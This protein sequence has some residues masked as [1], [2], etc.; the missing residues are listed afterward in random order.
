MSTSDLNTTES[1]LGISLQ[2]TVDTNEIDEVED[3]TTLA[4]GD[5]VGADTDAS[6][7]VAAS[8]DTAGD[9]SSV[10]AD[11]DIAT[12]ASA[13]VQEEAEA[14]DEEDAASEIADDDSTVLA[15]SDAIASASDDGENASGS[16]DE[17]DASAP[18]SDEDLSARA[19]GDVLISAADENDAETLTAAEEEETSST[20]TD[21]STTV[22]VAGSSSPLT[23]ETDKS[24]YAPGETAIITATDVTVGGTVEFQ[25]SHLSAGEDGVLLTSDDVVDDEMNA[26]GSGHESWLVTDGAVPDDLDGEANGTIVTSWY[27]NPDD[28]GG[29]T[30][31]LSA[32]EL[33]TGKSATTFFTDTEPSSPTLDLTDADGT[34]SGV[35]NGAFFTI[36]TGVGGT[37]FIDSF[38]RVQA[39]GNNDG[40]EQGYN[41]DNE[42]QF[43]AKGVVQAEEFTH[44]ILLSDVPRFTFDPDGA[45]ALPLGVYR[46]FVLDVNEPNDG[47]NALLSLDALQIFLGNEPDLLH[48][49]ENVFNGFGG[50]AVLVYD[51]EDS[52]VALSGENSHL[53]AGSGKVNLKVYISDSLFQDADDFPYVYLYSA[54]GFQ[55][56]DWK[57]DGG[58]EEW[59]VRP[60]GA[61]GINVSGYKWDDTNGNGE[62]DEGEP[63]IAG[64]TIYLDTDDDLDNGALATTTNGDGHYAFTNLGAGTYYVYEASNADWTNTYDGAT[65]FTA[66][67]LGDHVG[68]FETTEALNF[69]NFKLFDISGYKWNDADGDSLWDEGE[70]GIAGWTIYLDDDDDP[71]NG[72]LDSTDTDANGFYHF[73]NV[74]PG[75]YHVYE[76]SVPNWTNTFDGSLT[77]TAQSGADQM[78]DFGVAEPL[79]FGNHEFEGPGVRT[80]GFWSSPIGKPFWDGIG[81]NESK[82]GQTGFAD[83][84]L[85]YAVDSDGNGTLD[86]V[87][88]LL[89][90]DYDHDGIRNGDEDVFFVSLTDAQKIINASNKELQDV[91]WM[92]ARDAIATWLNDLAG[93]PLGDAEHC[94]DEAIDWL[95]WTSDDGNTLFGDW[96]GGSALKASSSPWGLGINTNDGVPGYEIGAGNTIHTALDEYNNNGT[97]N[98][99]QCAA[100]GDLSGLFV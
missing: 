81:G 44:S 2:P 56:G 21:D 28:S 22:T 88:G 33:A 71:G 34:T 47:P 93:N 80:P 7:E 1:E 78:G 77:F 14:G 26:S 85:L 8:S 97:V 68:H 70:L 83:G 76:A 75:T 82:A 86:A 66:P 29:A 24:D 96:G 53:V 92:L 98:G 91:R 31:L 43:D 74:G 23:V 95:Q 69:G 57:A 40:S 67:P 45:G 25:V 19:G 72:V 20:A 87:K 89:I 58:F 51:M 41:T 90:G 46:E 15:G 30:F 18:A 54:F 59:A 35:V 37:G 13:P 84:E 52:W 27:V 11:A 61:T 36:T 100:D 3:E 62:W 73:D 10:V 42:P 99:I 12:D 9:E 4:A 5:E 48:V 50:N 94:L 38:L 17:T 6:G 39:L 32:S 16:G 49:G 63:G 79:N 65:S 60:D 64:W 55:G